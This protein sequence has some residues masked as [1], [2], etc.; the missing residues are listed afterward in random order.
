MGKSEGKR[1]LG[2]PRPLREDNIKMDFQEVG[3]GGKDWIE[4]SQDTDRCWALVNSVMNF[5]SPQNAGTFFTG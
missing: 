4:L 3:C 5:R 1:S 2:R